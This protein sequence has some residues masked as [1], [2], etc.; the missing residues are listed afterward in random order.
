MWNYVPAMSTDEAAGIVARAIAIEAAHDLALRGR[1]SA[2]RRITARR[3]ADRAA[4]WPPTT[5]AAQ[6]WLPERAGR[7]SASIASS[8]VD[9]PDPP[10]PARPGGCSRAPLRRDPGDGRRG[11]G[12]AVPATAPAVI[13]ELGV[14]RLRRP[15]RRG[16]LDRRTR[17]TPPTGCP[18]GDRVAIMC[19]NHRGFLHAA[20]A[21]SRL[22]CDL[23]PLN[24]D[25]AGPQLGEVLAPRGASPRPSTT[26][27]SSRCS[28]TSGFERRP[29][30]SPGTRTARPTRPT[31]R[32]AD[33]G[34][35]A[36]T[37]PPPGARRPRDDAHLGH[38]RHA[39]GCRR[40]RSARCRSRRWRSRACSTSGGSGAT[41]Q[42]G[43]PFVVAPPLFHLFGLVGTMAAFALGSPVVLRRRFDP[44][45]TLEQIERHRAGVLLA[46][47]TMLARIMA[48]PG[49]SRDELR[50]LVAADDRER[51]RAAAS[52]A[53]QAVMDQFGDVLYN[54]YAST[55]VGV[56]TLATPAD[57]RT[58]PGTVGKP[59]AG[60]QA[61]DP[62][63]RGPRAS[64]GRD[65]PDLHRQPAAVRGL[66]RRWR[67]GDDRRADEHRRPRPPRPAGAAV[68]RRPRRRHDRLGR[69]ERVPA[70]GRGPAVRT[71]GR[72]RR[73]RVRCSRRAVRAAAGG[74]A[75]CSSREPRRP[76]T[77]SR[78]TSGTAR[79]A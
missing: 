29:G 50:H 27:S 16:A 26:R 74:H 34:R 15:R 45:A 7:R 57:L 47:P 19:R 65:R 17:S 72:R 60:R 6:T 31:T 41:P 46:V 75:S 55:E 22:G 44:E 52:G 21:A 49:R 42:S 73:R 53:R 35:R 56:G 10:G 77:S 79:A 18:A 66:H 32:R 5:E 71:R 62:R 20:I 14:D 3:G 70:G 13:D 36:A 67:Q 51:R 8:R 58:A 28:T 40:A 68:H 38:D 9:P 12:R 23:V 4:C 59:M 11:R 48:L 25:F 64:A 76:R 33:R 24:N 30:S 69:R 39:K 2:R 1:A 61:P 78:T 63:R 54:G 37:R 43:A